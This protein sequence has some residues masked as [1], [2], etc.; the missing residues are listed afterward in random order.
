MQASTAPATNIHA[1]RQRQEQ[2][3]RSYERLVRKVA[4]KLMTKLPD[5]QNTVECD[6]LYTI[7]MMGLFEADRTFDE[8][9]GQTFESFAEFRIRGAMLDELRK[10]DFFPRRLRTK[11]NKLHRAELSLK[12]TLGRDPSH[13]ELAEALKMSPG[14]LHQLRCETMPYTFV[15]QSDP[16]LTLQDP[17][18]E[19][20][21]RMEQ[22]EL[23]ALLIM[24]LEQL[25]E[26]EKLVLDLYYIQE[27]T[28]REIAGILGLTEGRISQIKSSAITH[29]RGLLI[30]KLN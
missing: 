4:W 9:V 28:Q 15:D 8:T 1:L 10:R 7:G 26:R 6:D 13:V 21:R 23:R 18:D 20:D 25:S 16:S 17:N 27:L 29:L 24:S 14:E 22:E 19:P 30:G 3:A 12:A 5:G 11:A 2:L